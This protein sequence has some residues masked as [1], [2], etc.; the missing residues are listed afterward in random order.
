MGQEIGDGLKEVVIFLVL[1]GLFHQLAAGFQ[2]ATRIGGEE[3]GD[4][5]TLLQNGRI[6][7]A[8]GDTLGAS[9]AIPPES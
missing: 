4:Y 8:T 9:C 6:S 2:H 3:M 5:V 1:F 7:G